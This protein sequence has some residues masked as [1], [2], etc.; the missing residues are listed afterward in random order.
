V[1]EVRSPADM[2]RSSYQICILMGNK[3]G[4]P[5]SGLGRETRVLVFESSG[6]IFSLLHR[7]P[8]QQD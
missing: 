2:K 7:D 3:E 4:K 1:F 5:D 6:S 8:R